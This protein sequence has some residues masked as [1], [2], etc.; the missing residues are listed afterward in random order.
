MTSLLRPSLPPKRLLQNT[1]S[2]LT[3]KCNS[4]TTEVEWG[5]WPNGLI[6]EGSAAPP[7][8]GRAEELPMHSLLIAALFV[9]MLLSPC[10]VAMFTGIE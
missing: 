1:P 5:K 8:S 3:Q 7:R 6:L 2:Q 10:V 9:G 4:G